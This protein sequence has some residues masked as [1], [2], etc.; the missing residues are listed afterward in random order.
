M[1]C[2]E[3]EKP[4]QFRYNYSICCSAPVVIDDPECDVEDN[5]LEIDWDNADEGYDK[6]TG[7]EEEATCVNCG[8]VVQIDDIKIVEVNQ[9]AVAS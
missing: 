8:S 4:S 7:D 6:N 1:K 5:Y 9:E 2:P 3:C